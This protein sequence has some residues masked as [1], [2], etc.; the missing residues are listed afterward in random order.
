MFSSLL[1]S[2][3]VYASLFGIVAPIVIVAA[4]GYIW[5]RARMPYDG[6][7]VSRLVMLIGSP[8]L[9]VSTFTHARLDTA[10][11]GQMVLV[12]ACG[13]AVTAVVFV[14]LLRIT[15]MPVRVF[16]PP[17]LFPNCGN[18]GLPLSL[19]AFGKEGL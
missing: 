13:I 7:F 1:S 4:I 14:V 15:G 9:I 18:A 11:F 6:D 5:G 17:M 10:L 2:L 16:L 19:F 3:S 8:C 12:A